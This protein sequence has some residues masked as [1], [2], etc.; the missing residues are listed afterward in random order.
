M[1]QRSAVGSSLLAVV[2]A[3]AAAAPV[4]AQ[5]PAPDLTKSGWTFIA[6]SEDATVYMKN[7]GA[8]AGPTRQ[9]W[10][11]YDL[12]TARDREGFSFRSVKSLGEYDCAVRR[13][14]VLGETFHA[15][16]GLA[17]KD[18][19]PKA[20]VATDWASPSA[21]SIGDLRMAFACPKTAGA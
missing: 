9:A 12:D 19:A 5:A 16:R 2:C 20:F 1:V 4:G 6:F 10:T 14:R 3:L 21:G 8:P 7:A 17:G 18:W 13:S 11:A 15:E